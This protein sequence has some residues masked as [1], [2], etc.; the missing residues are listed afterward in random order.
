ML[1]SRYKIKYKRILLKISGEA[2]LGDKRYNIDPEI[3]NYIATEISEIHKLGVAVMIV[4][5]GGNIIRGGSSSDNGIDRVTA[6]YMGMLATVI[7]A[8]ALQNAIEKLNIT[9]RVLS[10]IEAPKIAE[11]FIKRRA[12]RHLE[13]GRIVIFAGGTGNPYF[14]TDMAAAL[15]AS[16]LNADVILKATKVDGVYSADPHKFEK[17]RFYN[18][19]TYLDVINKKLKVMD[20]TAISLCMENNIPIIVFNLLKKN[21]LK[22]IVIGKKIGTIIASHEL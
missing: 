3:V 11:P 18:S 6:D 20:L 12:D 14:S 5:G 1:K 8:L 21:A 10:A 13:K 4:I 2:L 22:N 7:N 16:E 19:L 17:A 15:R 9:T